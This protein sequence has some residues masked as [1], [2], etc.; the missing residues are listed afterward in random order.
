M[1]FRD[2]AP[3]ESRVVISVA[4]R[5]FSYNLTERVIQVM[6]CLKFRQSGKR[7][8]ELFGFV[9]TITNN[10]TNENIHKNCIDVMYNVLLYMIVKGCRVVIRNTAMRTF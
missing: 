4:L 6:K 9:T 2:I 1:G 3:N 5:Y 10:R 7:F 8:E